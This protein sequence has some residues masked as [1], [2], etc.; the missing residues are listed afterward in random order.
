MVKN[1]LREIPLLETNPLFL[2]RYGDIYP[3]SVSG[4]IF[5][6]FWISLGVVLVSLFTGLVS[7]SLNQSTK[8]DYPIA[9]VKVINIC[10]VELLY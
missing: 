2:T 5:S 6:M 4:R 8:P 1:D 7:A 10:Q 3:K 9:G